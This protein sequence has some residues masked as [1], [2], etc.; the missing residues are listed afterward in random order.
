MEGADTTSKALMFNSRLLLLSH[1]IMNVAVRQ[2][3][4]QRLAAWTGMYL[5]SQEVSFES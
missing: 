1:N 5:H 2:V 3:H 4:G